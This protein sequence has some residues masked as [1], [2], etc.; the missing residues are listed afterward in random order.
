MAKKFIEATKAKPV[1]KGEGLF[2][3][4]LINEGWGSSGYYSAE[5]LKENAGVFNKG[6]LSYA[7]H[8]TMEE[9]EAGRD[10]TK[11]VGR[12]VEDAVV[13]EDEEG[14]VALW[15]TLKV[16]PEWRE[17]VEEF[18]ESIGVSIFVSGEA[19]EGEAEGRSGLIVESLDGDDPYKSVDL[20][21]AAGRGGKIDRMLEAYKANEAMTA[22]AKSELIRTAVIDTYEHYS[23]VEDYD[24]STAYINT[25]DGIYAVP[26][27]VENS[28]VTLD[29]G[30]AIEVRREVQYIPINVTEK[31]ET[32]ADK[33]IEALDAKV[34]ALS[35]AVTSLVA[36][37]KPAEKPEEDEV[38]RAAVTESAVDAGLSKAS[39]ARVLKA[40][41]A[42]EKPE[43]AIKAEKDFVAE[44]LAE[45]ENKGESGGRIRE[46]A[47]DAY[48]LDDLKF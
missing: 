14:K 4:K 34:D 12:Y 35:E 11:I 17:F 1:S 2:R 23:W 22:N 33:D 47:T 38:D 13:E 40:V 27:S 28:V 24:D 37:L 43:D 8:S 29:T 7:N 26:Y 31:E 15:S 41:E 45:A 18:K 19:S 20:V 16:R 5:M 42:G 21:A 9:L 36:A 39:R 44:V 10:I 6:T 32:M 25:D 30:N 3:V 48:T 46:G